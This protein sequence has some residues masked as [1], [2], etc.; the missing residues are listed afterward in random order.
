MCKAMRYRHDYKRHEDTIEDYLDAN[1]YFELLNTYVTIDGEQKPYKFFSDWRKI[2]L[3]LSTDGMCPF[4]R[5]KNSCWPLIL[6]NLNLPPDQR[7]HLENLICVGVIPGPKSP[8]NL[9]SFLWPLIEELLELASGVSAVDISTQRLFSLRAHLL[10]AFG[11]IPAITKLLEFVGHN[12]RYPC[13]FCLMSAIQGATAGGGTHLYCPLHRESAPFFDPFH[14]PPRTHQECMN[15]GLEVLQAHSKHAQSNL[16]TSTGIKGISAL[17]RLA[18]ISIPAS[19]PID[20][21]HMIFINLIPQ[22]VDIWTGAFNGMGEGKETYLID[23]KLFKDIGEIVYDSG[24][25]MPTSYG[26]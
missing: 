7:T 1:R 16:A 19:F 14:L 23:S 6:V 4:K 20:I 2:A 3:A 24:S 11:D 13:R 5:R 18:S 15:K 22:L 26:C 21:M 8:K 9:G 17:A 12:G 10:T 25:T